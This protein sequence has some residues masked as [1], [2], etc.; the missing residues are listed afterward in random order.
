MVKIDLITGFLGSGK[1]T[2]I[3]KYAKYLMSKNENI[4]ILEN[5]YGPINV[6][7]EL[8]T[9]IGCK[10]EMVSGGCD[11]DCHQRRFKT[12]LIQMA[13]DK[14]DRVIVEPSG[15]FDPD[16]FFDTLYDEPLNNWYEIGN[17]FC[18]YDINT[19][20]L[21]NEAE[22]ILVSEASNASKLIVSKRKDNEILDLTYINTLMKKYN[23]N[24]VFSNSDVLYTDDLDFDLII[25]SGYKDYS[26]I[27]L[28]VMDE[29][30]FDSYFVFDKELSL[31]DINNIKD[32]LFKDNTY[33]KII[34]LK[35]FIFENN[36][37]IKINIT[38]KE[39]DISKNSNGQKV[40][41]IIGENLNKE[42]INTL[43]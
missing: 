26:H 36:N 11:R 5:D 18:I 3:K 9:D 25:N 39:C 23:C 41:I 42:L 28:Q 1:T 21:S 33:G 32:K 24:R 30:N 10:C 20:N 13:M 27:K 34:R 6:D 17:I 15:I 14:F 4:C 40:I 37:W 16:E 8:I 12:K 2:F 31:N 22:Y 43:F 35:G 7:M 19:K 38:N 29:N